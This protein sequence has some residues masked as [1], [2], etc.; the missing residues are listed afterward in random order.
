MC[1][2]V[3][4]NLFC[5]FILGNKGYLYLLIIDFYYLFV[6]VYFFDKIMIEIVRLIEIFYDGLKNLDRYIVLWIMLI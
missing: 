1:L 3:E 5:I 2:F 6:F 4:N